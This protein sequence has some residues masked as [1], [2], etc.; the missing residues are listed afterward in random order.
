MNALGRKILAKYDN[1]PSMVAILGA[2]AETKKH[3]YTPALDG[4]DLRD[5]LGEIE[6]RR[7]VEQVDLIGMPSSSDT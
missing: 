5:V 3:M 7:I 1:R 6:A 4:D 2:I